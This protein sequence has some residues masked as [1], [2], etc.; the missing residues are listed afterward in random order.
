[1]EQ[2]IDGRVAVIASPDGRSAPAAESAVALAEAASAP[3]G[4]V[5]DAAHGDAMVSL[6][7]NAVMAAERP[8]TDAVAQGR[9]LTP[10]LRAIDID[11]TRVHLIDERGALSIIADASGRLSS[12]PLAVGSINLDHVH[13]FGA[14]RVAARRV[15]GL[16]ATDEVEWL[17]LIDGA[18]IASHA[19]R[20]TNERHP[21]LSGSDLIAGVL[22][23]A[24]LTAR[25]VGVLG[26]S[27]AVTESLRTRFGADWPAVRFAGHWTPQRAALQD[28][29]ANED[30]AGQIN[31][32]GVDIL[33]V[34]LGKPRQE[35]W[36]NA[37]APQTGAGALLAFGAVVDFLAGRV[38]RAPRWV[39]DAGFEWAWRLMREPRRL[40]RRYLVQ[41]PP[42]YLAVHR[43]KDLIG[44]SR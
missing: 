2:T 41:G 26:G 20:V 32:A 6:A 12:K 44:A 35:Q 31:E 5:L 16:A 9:A 4:A 42:A 27:P 10:R 38:T 18:P 30:L 29:A 28:A 36:I 7:G 3:W 43:S 23:D 19:R 25:S 40:A 37:F 14:S 33:L 24:A 15:G 22:D 1:M 17:N 21:K 8:G 39:A 13:H 11:G 34:C